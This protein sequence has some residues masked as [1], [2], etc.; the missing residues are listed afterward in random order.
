MAYDYARRDALAR[1]QG[2]A[3]YYDKRRELEFANKAREF[4]RHIPEGAGGSQHRNFDEARLF[5]QAFKTGGKDD[6]R[7]YRNRR[8][9]LIVRPDG[10]GA[11]AKWIIDVAGYVADYDEWR[12]RYPHNVRE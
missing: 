5:F 9:E 2:F 10:R 8:G 6:Y 11:R 3:S 1:E 7:V 12:Q 4:R